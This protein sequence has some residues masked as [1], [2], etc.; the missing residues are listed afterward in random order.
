MGSHSRTYVQVL[1]G[2]SL[3][4]DKK[5][6]VPKIIIGMDKKSMSCIFI[7]LTLVATIRVIGVTM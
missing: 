5:G 7:Y 4:P 2:S 1:F 3:D 6:K